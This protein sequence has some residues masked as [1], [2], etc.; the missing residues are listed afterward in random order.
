MW[1]GKSASGSQQSRPRVAGA[2]SFWGPTP[3]ASAG[4]K[5]SSSSSSGSF[6]PSQKQ[7]PGL[8]GAVRYQQKELDSVVSTTATPTYPPI[9]PSPPPSTTSAPKQKSK[10][11]V[12]P[13]VDDGAPSSKLTP[14]HGVGTCLTMHQPWASLLV[15][16][17]KKIEGRNWNTS[18]RGTLWIH[19]ASKVPDPE[20]IMGIEMM[21]AG[22]TNKQFPTDYPISALIGCV[23]VVDVMSQ[24][25]YKRKHPVPEEENTSSFLWLC[26]N[27]Q[28]LPVP[29]GMSGKH[30]LWK[31]EKRIVESAE[32]QLQERTDEKT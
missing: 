10:P 27:P 16:G 15:Y 11:S 12:K 7:P 14:G 5:P 1:S 31:I 3:T 6:G 9:K 2:G 32:L 20:D 28:R 23:E 26:E 8:R 17:I 29:L 22:I 21:Y 4:A 18:H 25:E 19:S 13:K 24:E 30:K